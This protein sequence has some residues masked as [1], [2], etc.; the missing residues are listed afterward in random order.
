MI[1][2]LLTAAACVDN[3]ENSTLHSLR[4]HEIRHLKKTCVLQLDMHQLVNDG[5][6]AVGECSD[7]PL[8]SVSN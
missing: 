4:S 5:E 8:P 1:T 2:D 7:L 6:I 3:R